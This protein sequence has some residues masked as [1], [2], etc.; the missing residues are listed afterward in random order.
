MTREKLKVN[1][2]IDARVVALFVQTAS[3]FNSSI[4]VEFDNKSVNAKSIM[5]IIALGDLDG[6]EITIIADG[7]DEQDAIKEIVELLQK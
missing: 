1:L 3:K 5:G 7:Y 2:S 6:K 4:R